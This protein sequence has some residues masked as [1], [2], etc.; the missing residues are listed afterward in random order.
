VCQKAHQSLWYSTLLRR[1]N[2]PTSEPHHIT[3]W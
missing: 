2:K 3:Y 1:Q